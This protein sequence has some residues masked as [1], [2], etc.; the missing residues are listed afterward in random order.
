MGQYIVLRSEPVFRCEVSKHSLQIYMQNI[1]ASILKGFFIAL[2]GWIIESGGAKTNSRMK[3]LHGGSFR[4]KEK[5]CR[6]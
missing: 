1:G 5:D 4:K 2:G 6:L 3:E